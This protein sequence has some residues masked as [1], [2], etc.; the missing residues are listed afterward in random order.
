[1]QSSRDDAAGIIGFAHRATE[2]SRP[3]MNVSFAQFAPIPKE[4]RTTISGI[5]QASERHKPDDTCLG[6]FLTIG[7]AARA[8][9]AI[10]ISS[11]ATTARR[12]KCFRMF[13]LLMRIC[14]LE[15]ELMVC[16]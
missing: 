13:F 7:G 1:V 15:C 11:N 9:G 3:E 10:A 12:T 2:F 14:P 16:V 8:A 6:F 5:P 4:R